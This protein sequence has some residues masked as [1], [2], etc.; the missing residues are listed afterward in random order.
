M[1]GQRRVLLDLRKGFARASQGVR[2]PGPPP[3]HWNRAPQL[4]R[5]RGFKVDAYGRGCEM[6]P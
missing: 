4:R 2:S 5:R 6:L 3:S 1:R